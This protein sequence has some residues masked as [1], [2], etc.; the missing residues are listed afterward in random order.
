MFGGE[1][2]RV[3]LTT[4]DFPHQSFLEPGAFAHF[5]NF[6]I[7]YFWEQCQMLTPSF[8]NDG[9]K[10]ICMFQALLKKRDIILLIKA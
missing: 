8:G 9:N 2:V 7:T 1:D 5:P 6:S 10:N 4:S 3:A